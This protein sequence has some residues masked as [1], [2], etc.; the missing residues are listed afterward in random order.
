MPQQFLATA[1][2]RPELLVVQVGVFPLSYLPHRHTLLP[3]PLVT[4]LLRPV[5]LVEWVVLEVVVMV[6]VAWVLA[7]EELLPPYRQ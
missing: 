5:V 7:L 3:Q 1:L 4:A 6:R 2:L